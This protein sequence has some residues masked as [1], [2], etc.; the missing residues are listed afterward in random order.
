MFYKFKLKRSGVEVQYAPNTNEPRLLGEV[1]TD[2][3]KQYPHLAFAMGRTEEAV[4]SSRK[5][6][7][8]E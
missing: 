2:V 4:Y 7:T 5:E 6:A 8:D 1:F 3:V